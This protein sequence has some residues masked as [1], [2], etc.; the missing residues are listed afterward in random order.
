MQIPF[1]TP[2]TI[3]EP[4]IEI[5]PTLANIL[6][7]FDQIMLC[8][9]ENLNS[10]KQTTSSQKLENFIRRCCPLS[11]LSVSFFRFNQTEKKT[12]QNPLFQ[13]F[14]PDPGIPGKQTC[15]GSFGWWSRLDDKPKT[16][17]AD[18]FNSFAKLKIEILFNI[19]LEISP[20]PMT[21]KAMSS[22]VDGNEMKNKEPFLSGKQVK[23]VLAV[24]N[25]NAIL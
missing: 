2:K 5:I 8:H 7:T 17:T 3:D 12:K 13:L 6:S 24:S 11:F 16:S 22:N 9:S 25:S 4:D 14:Q 18:K 1:S 19:S 23:I 21:I 10:S 15:V 20:A